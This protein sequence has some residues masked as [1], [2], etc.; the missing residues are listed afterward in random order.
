MKPARVTIVEIAGELGISKSLVSNALHSRG[1]V[2]P[3]T[4]DLVQK[5]AAAMGYVSNRA[6]QQLRG[7]RYGTVGLCIPSRG[8]ALSFYMQLAMGIGDAA[9]EHG[10]NLML[11]TSIDRHEGAS[12]NAPVD[13]VIV[14]DPV[15]GEPLVDQ[16]A[17]AGIPVVTVGH[18][19]GSQ[20]ENISGSVSI[21]FDRVLRDVLDALAA[22]GTKRPVLLSADDEH[23]PVWLEEI[24]AT[25]SGYCHERGSAPI[26]ERTGPRPDNAQLKRKLLRLVH[27]EGADGFVV[28][29]QGMASHVQAIVLEEAGGGARPPAVAALTGDPMSDL[30]DPRILSV[31]LRAREY[32]RTALAMLQS[33]LDGNSNK[34]QIQEHEV[35]VQ[36]WVR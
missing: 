13:G 24:D 32:G 3:E 30:T 33:V 34:P 26:I 6:A 7:A 11:Y 16:F 28:A 27:E 17:A 35:Q 36:D 9:A 21:D 19:A 10:S 20:L 12:L 5:T 23:L 4:R 29:Y 31:D 15:P 2:S 25:Y 18:V 8:R 14:V 1:R 22:S